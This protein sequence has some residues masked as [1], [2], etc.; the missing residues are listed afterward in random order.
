MR[1]VW[2]EFASW[3]PIL[4]KTRKGRVTA[5]RLQAVILEAYNEILVVHGG[6]PLNV[7]SY[8]AHGLRLARHHLLTA[9]AKKIFVSSEFPEI[10]EEAFRHAVSRLSGIDN[11][12]SYVCLDDRELLDHCGHY[13]IYGSEHVCAIAAQLSRNGRDYRQVLKRVGTPTVFKIALP[14]EFISESDLSEL[15]HLV[16]ESLPKLRAGEQP[17]VANFT[18][19]LTRPVPGRFFCGHEHPEMIPDPLLPGRPPYHP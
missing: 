10:T 4:D 8:Y 5:K 3:Q 16:Q 2:K 17:L 14:L 15:A 12:K 18:F 13:L 1:F 6:R 7:Q 11:K 9:T 19:M